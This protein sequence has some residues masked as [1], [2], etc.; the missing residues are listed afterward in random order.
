MERQSR[1]LYRGHCLHHVLGPGHR[2]DQ[3]DHQ[4][5]IGP[6]L[7]ICRA[8][9]RRRIHIS[10]RGLWMIRCRLALFLISSLPVLG[11]TR[12]AA[13]FIDGSVSQVLL[14]D[15]LSLTAA[16]YDSNGNRIA[17]AQFTWAVSDKTVF[18]IDSTGAV[19]A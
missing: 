9:R 13:V 18:T 15:T 16:A 4:H 11:Q 14:N 1:N 7:R 2:L 6:R 3:P 12:A 19:K 10:E 17:S 8:G 5:T